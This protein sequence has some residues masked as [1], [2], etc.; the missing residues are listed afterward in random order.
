[1]QNKYIIH[2]YNNKKKLNNNNTKNTYK[3]W[4]CLQEEMDEKYIKMVL[5]KGEGERVGGRNLNGTKKQ[6]HHLFCQ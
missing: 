1:M 2:L 6:H 5:Y 4:E 3:N